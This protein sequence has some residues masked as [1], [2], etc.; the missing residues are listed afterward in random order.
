MQKKP[1]TGESEKIR[2]KIA[3]GRSFVCLVMFINLVF[4]Q[5]NIVLHC[6]LIFADSEDK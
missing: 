3:G 5:S 6:N 1:R 4:R 2:P